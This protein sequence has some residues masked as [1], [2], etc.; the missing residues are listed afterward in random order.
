MAYPPPAS[1]ST[2]LDDRFPNGADFWQLRAAR[3][4]LGRRPLLMGIVNVTPD[5]FSDGGQ[6]VD[7]S[8][9]VEQALRLAADGA[10]II[11]IGGEST[12]PGSESLAAKTE[13]ARVLPVIEA[14]RSHGH[15]P[16][17]IDTSKA[18]VARERWPPALRSSTT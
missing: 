8:A 10:D 1:L 18:V 13:L 17:S 7:V 2:R 3:L 6:F 16:L 5:S 15:V 12:R 4:R 14:L 11:D 9:A